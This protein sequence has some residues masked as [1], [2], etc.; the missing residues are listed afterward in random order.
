M[1]RRASMWEGVQIMEPGALLGLE[2]VKNPT[3]KL[4]AQLVLDGALRLFLR[5]FRP[6][7]LGMPDGKR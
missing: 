5:R 2:P 6:V 7:V 4:V 3:L 1:F